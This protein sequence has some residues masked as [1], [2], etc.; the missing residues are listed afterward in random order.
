MNEKFH[1][2]FPLFPKSENWNM[3]MRLFNTVIVNTLMSVNNFAHFLNHYYFV[4]RGLFFVRGL[5][6]LLLLTIWPDPGYLSPFEAQ[7]GIAVMATT[8]LKPG[9]RFLKPSL[10]NYGR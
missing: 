5:L 8:W 1:F 7:S 9:V 6:C 10:A 4:P 3:Q 2:I